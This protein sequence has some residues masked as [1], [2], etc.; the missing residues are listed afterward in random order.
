[1][2][3]FIRGS[4]SLKLER[5]CKVLKKDLIGRGINERLLTRPRLQEILLDMRALNFRKISLARV[6]QILS[7]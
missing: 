5:E 2:S 6:R 3:K 4:I 1:M 7:R